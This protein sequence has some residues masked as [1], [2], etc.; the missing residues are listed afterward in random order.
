MNW[1]IYSTTDDNETVGRT[2]SDLAIIKGVIESN[3]NLSEHFLPM[4]KSEKVNDI[5]K[6]CVKF[7]AK[8]DSIE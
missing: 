4:I 3:G 8:V 5:L 2:A 1:F 7:T 6:R